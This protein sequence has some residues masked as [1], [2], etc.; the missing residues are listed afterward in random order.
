MVALTFC[1]RTHSNQSCVKLSFPSLYVSWTQLSINYASAPNR[2]RSACAI[3]FCGGENL[4]I[5]SP[6][7]RG[8]LGG[9]RLSVW[10]GVSCSILAMKSSKVLKVC[11]RSVPHNYRIGRG[12]GCDFFER[13]YMYACTHLNLFRIFRPCVLPCEV[14]FFGWVSLLSTGPHTMCFFCT[15]TRVYIRK[16]PPVYHHLPSEAQFGDFWREKN[17]RTFSPAITHIDTLSW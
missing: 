3:Y 5:I 10:H 15:W 8:D 14:L 16:W 11:D 6:E 17:I 9:S 4:H 13:V 1:G 7:V 12:L 2:Q